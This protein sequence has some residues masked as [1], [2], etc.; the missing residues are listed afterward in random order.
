MSK[1]TA[2]MIP[3]RA[4]SKRVPNKNIR[5]LSGKPLISYVIETCLQT[6][7]DVWVNT[8]DLKI[9]R[10]CQELFPEV[11]IKKRKP[12]LCNDSAT[13]DDFMLDF[14]ESHA[15]YDRV[16]QVLPTSPFIT[17]DEIKSFH[18]AMSD[19]ETVV[20]IKNAQIGCVYEDNPINFSKTK[21]NPPSQTMSP[22]QIYATSLMGWNRE[23]FIKNMKEIGCAYHGGSDSVRYFEL[24][25]FSTIDIDNEEDFLLAEAVAQFLPFQDRYKKFYYEDGQYT[26]YVVPR[27]LKDDGIEKTTEL[28]PNQPVTSITDL[29]SEMTTKEAWYKTLI[30]SDSNSCTVVNQMPGEGNRRHYHAKWN[31]V[32]YILKGKWRFDIEDET[33]IVKEGDLVYINKGNKH[34]IT[35]IGDEMASRLAISRYDVEHIYDSKP[36]RLKP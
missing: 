1:R 14:M 25:G 34:K 32:W 35:A 17:V 4:G 2:I 36:K 6:D 8:D 33:H 11:N 7:L 3:A 24:N 10:M 30:D 12:E 19:Y 28:K 23:T 21:K 27:V 20:S 18:E 15:E 26:D 16:L 5:L 22:V 29:L 9:I 13:N 31:E